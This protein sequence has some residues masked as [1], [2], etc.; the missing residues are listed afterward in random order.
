MPAVFDSLVNSRGLS[1]HVAWRVAFIVPF[2]LITAVAV[3][4]LLLCED[5][6]TGKWS[7][8]H[9]VIQ[10]ESVSSSLP[11]EPFTEQV[12]KALTPEGSLRQQEPLSSEKKEPPQR[13][14][15][16]PEKEP[17]QLESAVPEPDADTVTAALGEV[18]VN[19]TPR[20]ALSVIFSPQSLALAALYACSFGE[21][22][23]FP[24]N[25]PPSL[26]RI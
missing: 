13:S 18:V 6:P 17:C 8:R 23:F 24:S 15:P 16:V 25:V 11:P 9:L 21:L 14:S 7:E 1:A 20:E 2:I 26:R 4:M 19:P 12:V 5:T 3:A 10:G 22:P